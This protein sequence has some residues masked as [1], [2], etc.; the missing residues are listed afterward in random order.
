MITLPAS[1]TAVCDRVRMIKLLIPK[2]PAAFRRQGYFLCA[3]G[4]IAKIIRD[5]FGVSPQESLYSIE[6][7]SSL[8]G[9]FR[10]SLFQLLEVDADAFR[11]HLILIARIKVNDSLVRPSFVATLIKGGCME[12]AFIEHSYC[13]QMLCAGIDIAAQYGF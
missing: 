12:A 10:G 3:N 9:D 4:T 11:Q 1:G 6:A 13:R 8:G 2:F 5:D 7:G